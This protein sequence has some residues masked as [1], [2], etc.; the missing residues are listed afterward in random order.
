MSSNKLKTKV[1]YQPMDLTKYD[2]N[3]INLFLPIERIIRNKIEGYK[4]IE[5]FKNLSTH[6]FI[7]EEIEFL[8]DCYHS[9]NY[10][11]IGVTNIHGERR[12]TITGIRDRYQLDVDIIKR[13]I[14]IYKKKLR[15]LKDI[16][17]DTKGNVYINNICNDV[18]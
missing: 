3:V 14:T 13:W 1:T 10:S 2:S 8:C 16:A 18:M 9:G 4:V 5:K 12:L 11:I 6:E 15:L 17:T 7:Q